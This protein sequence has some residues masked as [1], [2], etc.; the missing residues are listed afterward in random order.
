MPPPPDDIEFQRLNFNQIKSSLSPSL[1]AAGVAVGIGFQLFSSDYFFVSTR[2]KRQTPPLTT[3]QWCVDVLAWGGG[4]GFWQSW[5]CIWFIG[6][7]SLRFICHTNLLPS[8]SFS[9]FPQTGESPDRKG[10]SP[11]PPPSPPSP[12]SHANHLPT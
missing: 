2:N 8:S 11:P 3:L 12:A 1:L 7:S 9:Y 5:Q 4:G 6:G 10:P